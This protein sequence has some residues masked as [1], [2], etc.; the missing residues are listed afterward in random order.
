M[1]QG[2][3]PQRKERDAAVHRMTDLQS[4]VEDLLPKLVQLQGPDQTKA[5]FDRVQEQVDVVRKYMREGKPTAKLR[6]S[7]SD[8]DTTFVKL[9]RY[10]GVD[11]REPEARVRQAPK[12]L[13]S[14]RWATQPRS[15]WNRISRV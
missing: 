4:T 14:A 6:A 8:V 1:P 3:N 11:A 9:A 2:S 10:Y 13:L 7:W 12:A 5:A 15:S